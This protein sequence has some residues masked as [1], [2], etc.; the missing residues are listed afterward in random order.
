M[1]LEFFG[2]LALTLLL[3]G[4]LWRQ[5][6]VNGITALNLFAL[7]VLLILPG[8]AANIHLSPGVAY[9][10]GGDAAVVDIIFPEVA[11]LV[12]I[13][14]SALALQKGAGV[15]P[16]MV[17]TPEQILR[18]PW[19]GIAAVVFLFLV[20]LALNV[21]W[22]DAPLL[23]VGRATMEQ[24]ADS[25]DLFYSTPLLEA[26]SVLRLLVFYTLGPALF[27]MRGLGARVPLLL[28]GFLVFFG[29][30]TLAKTFF[31]FNALFFVAGRYLATGKFR[32][33]FLGLGATAG[34]LFWIVKSTFKS[35]VDREFFEVLTLLGSRI[36][37][38]PV[39]LSAMYKQL[40]TFD[41]GIR[42]SVWYTRLWGGHVQD[43]PAASMELVL[44]VPGQAPSGM[45][46][47]CYPNVPPWAYAPYFLFFVGFMYFVSGRASRIPN[48]LLRTMLILLVGFDGWFMLL[49]DPL[50]AMNSYG[51]LYMGII[52]VL[53]SRPGAPDPGSREGSFT[54]ADQ[55]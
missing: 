33:V 10:V 2:F 14:C 45:V 27:F 54:R 41:D 15:R 31:L 37:Q 24:L 52:C 48:P 9:V 34:C 1:T 35:V 26:T 18:L 32:E 46:G 4:I 16:G 38:V 19:Q 8:G 42:S 44:H 13:L 53:L 30:L 29:I 21:D 51:L 28:L 7:G 43:V 50:A 55:P 11:L 17:M 22:A 20:F 49:T 40:Y 39:C 6:K 36:I 5:F 25:R 12:L 23:N 47:S 3:G